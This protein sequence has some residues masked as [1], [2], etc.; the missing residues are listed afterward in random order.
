[1]RYAILVLA[2]SLYGST[3][4][5]RDLRADEAA[6]LQVTRDACKA[7]VDADVRRLKEVLTED[8]TLTD[9]DG[10]VTTRADE[11]GS[12]ETGAVRYEVFENYDMKVRL[13]GESAVVTGRTR[14]KGTAGTSAFA[15]AFQFTDSL[16]RRGDHWWF[17]SSHISRLAPPAAAP[18]DVEAELRR[19]TQENLDSI[20]PGQ[21]EVW[22]RNLHDKVTQLT[23]EIT[24][25]IQCTDGRLTGAR[26]GR[27]A[28]T[29][30]PEVA[31]VFFAPGKPRTRR[32]FLRDEKGAVTGFVDRREG[33][34]VRWV[35]VK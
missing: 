18:A 34:D 19:L 35:K 12:L 13:Y 3:V 2:F 23:P 29:Y 21:V 25:T 27:P 33:I 28:V 31:D 30:Q 20:A 7:F 11:I 26:T 32:I 8:F 10:T 22:R 6:I 1:M 9:P 17:T 15:A 16:V 5:A 4:T 14:V 24:D